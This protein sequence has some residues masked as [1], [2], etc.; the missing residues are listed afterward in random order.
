[1]LR[2]LELNPASAY[3]TEVIEAAYSSRLLRISCLTPHRRYEICNDASRLRAAMATNPTSQL[4]ICILSAR[5]SVEQ[6]GSYIAATMSNL[7][8]PE[9]TGIHEGMERY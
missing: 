5:G 6:S 9:R 4:T 1:M 3:L 7:V 2:E 8:A